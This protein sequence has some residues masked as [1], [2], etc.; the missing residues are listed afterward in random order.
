MRNY[1]NKPANNKGALFN[2]PVAT[3]KRKYKR[4]EKLKQHIEKDHYY[5]TRNSNNFK[6]DH[7]IRAQIYDSA[8]S[9]IIELYEIRK[10]Y[11]TDIYYGELLAKNLLPQL[12]GKEVTKEDLN[13]IMD[14]QGSFAKKLLEENLLST[15]WDLVMNDLEC[16]FN[17]GLPYYDTNF[18][19]TLTIDFLWHAMMQRPDLYVEICKKSCIEIMPHCNSYRT[20]DEDT[21]RYQYFMEIFKHKFYR[22]PC[23]F[24]SQLEVFSS[25]DIKHV[26]KDLCDKELNEI[27]TERLRKEE[28][29]KQ[30][31]EE[32]RRRTEEHTKLI[33]EIAENLQDPSIINEYRNLTGPLTRG[34]Q[35]GYR[36]EE[37][38][39]YVKLQEKLARDNY[40][41]STC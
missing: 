22:L 2:C 40:K 33:K 25:E 32:S 14:A 21:K 3:C 30:E 27:T 12:Y 6:F 4:E 15:N 24:S 23:P 5:D 11:E 10:C 18:C 41:P 36:S 39:D 13:R 34:Y 1:S 7:N 19:P 35:L 9:Y 8:A 37:L 17:I 20:E 28:K 16:F 31:I 26:F 29:I 38:K